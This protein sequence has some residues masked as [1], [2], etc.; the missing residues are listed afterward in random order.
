[1]REDR[2]WAGRTG[3]SPRQIE[4]LRLAAGISNDSDSFVENL[5]ATGLRARNQIL[6]VGVSGTGLCLTVHVLS[7]SEGH[8]SEVWSP[9]PNARRVRRNLQT[10]SLARSPDR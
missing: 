9:G 3:L 10:D 7:Q 2:V 8:I 4:H 1:M 6:L 5:D